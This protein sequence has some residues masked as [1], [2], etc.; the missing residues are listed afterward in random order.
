MHFAP[1]GLGFV[2]KHHQFGH[3]LFLMLRV[4]LAVVYAVRLGATNK[5]NLS[6]VLGTHWRIARPHPAAQ[7][8]KQSGHVPVSVSGCIHRLKSNNSIAVPH[9]WLVAPHA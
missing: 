6:P 3:R 2:L 7:P 8:M 9:C 5:T 1:F 4:V